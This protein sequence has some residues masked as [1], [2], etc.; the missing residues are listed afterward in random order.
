MAPGDP[1]TSMDTPKSTESGTSEPTAN[2]T[3][4]KEGWLTRLR[5]LWDKWRTYLTVAGVTALLVALNHFIDFASKTRDF[6]S[7]YWNSHT[8][9]TMADAS[10]DGTILVTVSNTGGKPSKLLAYRLNFGTLPVENSTL[11]LID[12]DRSKN[13]IPPRSQVPI[14]LT[15]LGLRAQVRSEGESERLSKTEI[16]QILKDQEVTLEIDVRESDDAQPSHFWNRRTPRKFHTTAD[17]FP[18]ERI[19]EFV[20]YWLP[21]HDVH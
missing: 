14:R 8:A 1:Q 12:E 18:A 11:R 3:D 13:V 19:R 10:D 20:L 15:V 4:A 5:P 2:P 21:E 6:L 7:P 9:I 17:Q 16:D